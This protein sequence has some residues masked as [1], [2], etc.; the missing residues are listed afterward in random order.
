MAR[1]ASRLPKTLTAVN[2]E[3]YPTGSNGKDFIMFNTNSTP[4]LKPDIQLFASDGGEGNAEPENIGGDA[5]SGGNSSKT[6][7]QA[8][9]DNIVNERTGRAA[10]SAL[11][12]FFEQKG[13]SEDEVNTAVSE[14]LENKKKNTPNVEE[15]RNT[16][17]SER[18]QRLKA[19][20]KSAATLEAI[21]QGVDVSA[22]A[23]VIKLAELKDCAGKDGGINAEKLTAAIKAVLDDVPAFKKSASGK[24]GIDK[25]GGDGES[26][27]DESGEIDAIRMAFGLK[28]KK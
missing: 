7:T 10:K 13:L 8:E 17:N 6:Y 28:P 3:E 9:L 16:I 14:Y 27:K 26:K 23:H 22:V 15:L 21:K 20:I 12:S 2:S 24:S 5:Q 18:S 1:I 25:V 19:E 4:A 11:K